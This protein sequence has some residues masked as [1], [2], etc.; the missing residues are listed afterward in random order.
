MMA[1]SAPETESKTCRECGV[2]KSIEDFY[3]RRD[4]GRRRNDCKA[5]GIAR[6]RG[7]AS[8]QGPEE[9]RA[10]YLRATFGLTQSDY[11]AML[12]VQ[13]GVCAICRRPGEQSY[14]GL[15][16]DHDHESGRVRGLLCHRCNMALGLLG[17]SVTVLA[18]AIAYLDRAR[19][20]ERA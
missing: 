17:D 13:D 5:C 15:H 14:K 11:E 9:N 2:E 10:K 6:M 4:T 18:E 20:S 1:S 12:T 19:S 8:T 16:I 7:L 3:V